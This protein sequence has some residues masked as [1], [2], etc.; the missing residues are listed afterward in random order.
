MFY[1]LISN[2]KD[3]PRQIKWFLQRHIRGWDDTNI[4]SL[5]YG[6]AKWFLPQL[7]KFR[8]YYGGIPAYIAS[9]YEDKKDHKLSKKAWGKATKEYEEMIDKIIWSFKYILADIGGSEYK[10]YAD[11]TGYSQMMSYLNR[12]SDVNW[13]RTPVIK[14]KSK[15]YND[16]WKEANEKLYEKYKEG[17]KLFAENLRALWT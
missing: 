11:E 8:E 7:L 5:D 3:T 17:M 15:K 9:K 13:D 1:R 6:L 14:I 16:K 12:S 10:K 2:I 4:W